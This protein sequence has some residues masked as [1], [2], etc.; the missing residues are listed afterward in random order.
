MAGLS[1]LCPEDC[2]N[3]RCLVTALSDRFASAYQ[4][5]LSRV[6]FKNRVKQ[7]DKSLPELSLEIKRLV[8]LSY[9]QAL[10]TLQHVLARDQFIDVKPDEE[11]QLKL[12]HERPKT[13]Q[14]ALTLVLEFESFYLAARQQRTRYARK[15][16]WR[17]NLVQ[18]K[19][20]HQTSGVVAVANLWRKWGKETT[21]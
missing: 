3:F 12:K 6:H 7:R 4:T 20:A 5:E 16:H 11:T 19:D 10:S 18:K 13:I 8:R 21:N 1:S 2:R 9:L 15:S 14:E 17:L